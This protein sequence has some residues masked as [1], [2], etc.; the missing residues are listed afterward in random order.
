MVR[1]INQYEQLI[2]DYDTDEGEGQILS[3]NQSLSGLLVNLDL[4]SCDHCEKERGVRD[5]ALVT[6]QEPVAKASYCS[7]SKQVFL[8]CTVY[9]YVKVGGVYLHRATNYLHSHSD[10]E[11]RYTVG[12]GILANVGSPGEYLRQCNNWTFLSVIQ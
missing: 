12:R 5:A 2:R 11:C 7:R 1:Y 9:V 4:V 8:S 3:N 6:I 10:I